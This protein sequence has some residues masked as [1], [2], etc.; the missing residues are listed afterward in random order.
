MRALFSARRL[1]AIVAAF[2]GIF[3]AP[4]IFASLGAEEKESPLDVEVRV[5]GIYEGVNESD[6]TIYG[7]RARV[8]ID[9]PGKEIVLVLGAETP[10]SWELSLAGDTKVKKVIL[11]GKQPQTVTGL[12]E[13][14]PIEKTPAGG[15]VIGRFDRD[16]DGS[17]EFA[18]YVA[19]LGRRVTKPPPARTPGERW[20]EEP[21]VVDSVHDHLMLIV[22]YP[23]PTP[24]QD[25]PAVAGEV[26]GK[27]AFDAHHYSGRAA[28]FGEHTLQGPNDAKL[29]HLPG[30]VGR[31]AF[32]PETKE[33]Y[34]IANHDFVK[35]NLD[36]NRFEKIDVGANVPRLSWPGEITFDTKRKRVILGTT[37][38]LYTYA[39]ATGE[40]SILTKRP[41][42]FDFFAWS[43]HD[44]RLYGIASE[45][46]ERGLHVF[47]TK[48]NAHGALL[49]RTEL[50]L[51]TR[52]DVLTPSG[53][54]L[55][56]I[57]VVPLD[58]YVV[59][60]VSGDGGRFPRSD[61]PA[62]SHMYLV[63]ADSGKSWWTHWKP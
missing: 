36:E 51:P 1:A 53:P 61:Q 50:S 18:K 63:D 13:G 5:V 6:G 42:L 29:M 19:G 54:G 60:L 25:L 45:R 48:V 47:L 21:V 35:V 56:P 23:Q 4:G 20:L 58:G 7:P 28:F 46:D 8:E 30:R 43:P 52:A 49:S 22:G 24:A 26:A 32:D 62:E 17:P 34:G 37:K 44:D 14:V 27:I 41:G 55:S 33:C 16:R 3:A 38:Y 59:I 12:P 11:D 10:A 39:P 2:V 9:R 57:S 15:G 31:V 40:W